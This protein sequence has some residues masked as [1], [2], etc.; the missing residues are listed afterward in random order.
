MSVPLLLFLFALPGRAVCTRS[1]M[2]LLWPLAW[3]S[4]LL[5][6]MLLMLL[7]LLLHLLPPPLPVPLRFWLLCRLDT[8]SYESFAEI[9]DTICLL[10]LYAILEAVALQI[11]PLG[12]LLSFP[13]HYIF[14]SFD[15]LPLCCRC[16]NSF[17]LQS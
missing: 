15:Q 12:G 17:L 3:T 5:L 10:V 16:C 9:W 14:G 13:A 4:L 6:L 8:R 2:R 1:S 7:L 11:L